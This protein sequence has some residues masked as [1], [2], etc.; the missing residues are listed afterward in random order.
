M[1]IAPSGS[2]GAGTSARKVRIG[3]DACCW[4]NR[5]GF[6]R[7]TRELLT[8]LVAA[9][10]E[11]EYIFF[12]DGDTARA[13][14]FPPG[15]RLVVASTDVSP[16]VAAAA[17]G[18]R[19]LKDLWAL[20][21]VVS[22]EP[23]DLFFFPAVYSYFPILNRCKVIVT[24]HDMIADHH[25]ERVF[26]NRKSLLFWKLKQKIALWQ[27]DR[28][29]T[30]SH[31]AKLQIVDYCR[32]PAALV[33]TTT[34][35]PNDAFVRLPSLDGAATILRTYGLQSDEPFL[36][37]VGGISP[38]KNLGVLV[39]AFHQLLADARFTQHKLVLVGDYKGDV[40]FSH[41]AALQ[42]K[43][44][45]LDLADRV[46]FTGYVPDSELV[47]LYN[48]AQALV[49]PSLEEGFGLPAVEAMACGTPV[50]ASDRGSLPEVVG[51]AGVFFDPGR[52]DQL[53][54]HLRDVL[55]SDSARDRMSRAGLERSKLF[56]WELAAQSTRALFDRVLNEVR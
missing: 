20:T 3:V 25:P 10:R 51:E 19:S 18:N 35:G 22:Q 15:V 12:V 8:A 29:L 6:G 26:P 44:D 16:T 50:I 21:R 30:V 13:S 31:H 5:R 2:S 34:E 14:E 39:E 7:F 37:Y 4:S 9:D 17:S 43:I 38:H 52:P 41:Y 36:I 53:L 55:G 28:I 23:L 56:T 40:F 1:G 33:E 45:Q 54:A 46:L 11:R 47:V 48:L 42:A 24:I 49:L 32:I 27:S